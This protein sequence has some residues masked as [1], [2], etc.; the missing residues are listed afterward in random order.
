MMF[1]PYFDDT[2]L[3]IWV[4]AHKTPIR[5]EHCGEISIKLQNPK[6]RNNIQWA[7]KSHEYK[8]SLNDWLA[9]CF[10]CHKK[11]DRGTHSLEAWLQKLND[12]ENG[13][14]KNNTI[15]TF[16]TRG[17]LALLL[18]IK[19]RKIQEYVRLGMPIIE[20][21]DLKRYD[22]VAVEKWLSLHE[23]SKEFSKAVGKVNHE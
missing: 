3:H 21:G 6:K 7:N 5:C 8:E 16:L 2:Q 22:L 9:L 13:T 19:E 11:Y 23:F 10:K 12:F 17:H 4:H 18:N 1:R 20:I 15:Y 14:M